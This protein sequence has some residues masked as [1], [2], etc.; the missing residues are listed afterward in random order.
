MAETSAMQLQGIGLP[1][2]RANGGS[3]ASAGRKLRPNRPGQ[4]T[5]RNSGFPRPA[6]GPTGL[7]RAPLFMARRLINGQS[8]DAT[9]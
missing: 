5:G 9:A 2:G 6:Q 8:T 3:F 4:R 1:K 7:D